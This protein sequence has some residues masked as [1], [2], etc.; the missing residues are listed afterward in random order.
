MVMAVAK[1]RGKANGSNISPWT[2]D[3][4]GKDGELVSLGNACKARMLEMGT[5]GCRG[6]HGSSRQMALPMN[7]SPRNGLL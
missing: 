1:H 3:L 6:G 4:T 7:A 2:Y 5:Q